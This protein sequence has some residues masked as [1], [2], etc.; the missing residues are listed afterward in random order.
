LKFKWLRAISLR[1]VCFS[2]VDDGQF[3]SRSKGQVPVVYIF[4]LLSTELTA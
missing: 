4:F 2:G 1:F 3:I